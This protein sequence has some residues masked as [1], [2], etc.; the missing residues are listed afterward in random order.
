MPASLA[1]HPLESIKPDT[2][3][4]IT[5]A[6][7]PS[8]AVTEV[9][10]SRVSPTATEGDDVTGVAQEIPAGRMRRTVAE[11]RKFLG[12]A[13]AHAAPVRKQ[14]VPLGGQPQ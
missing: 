5:P 1:L 12:K 9:E 3:T 11:M 10:P 8:H 4:A 6:T 14:I 7:E 2:G 13:Q